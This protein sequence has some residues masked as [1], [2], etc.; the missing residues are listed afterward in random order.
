MSNAVT[1]ADHRNPSLT[2]ALIKRRGAALRLFAVLGMTSIP[3]A[4]VAQQGAARRAES[5]VQTAGIVRVPTA[6]ERAA[7][8]DA[9]RRDSVVRMARAQ[10]GRRYIFGGTTPSGFDCSGFTRYLMRALNVQLPRTAAEQARVGQEIPR[11]PARL[12][13]G[14]I[15]T[16]G[17]GSRV[18]HVGIYIGNG[19]YVHASS[20]AGRIVEADLNRRASS[21]VRAWTGVRRLLAG[22]DSTASVAAR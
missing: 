22:G 16:F 4:A 15:L 17:R 5:P 18:T 10:L 19:R 3:L 1:G 11:D 6:A 8:A 21:L 7:L 20:V 9:A 13:P 12:R 2:R 14:D